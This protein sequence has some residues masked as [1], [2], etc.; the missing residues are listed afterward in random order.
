M[1]DKKRKKLQKEVNK[2][3][4][5]MNFAIKNEPLQKGRYYARQI[6][7]IIKNF[8]DDSGIKMK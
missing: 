7:A 3:I 2:V 5:D 6:N 8:Y 1:R 4:K